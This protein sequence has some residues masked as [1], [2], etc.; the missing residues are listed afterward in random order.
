[1]S[2]VQVSLSLIGFYYQIFGQSFLNAVVPEK[3][4]AFRQSHVILKW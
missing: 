1:M 4:I 2:I 3:L